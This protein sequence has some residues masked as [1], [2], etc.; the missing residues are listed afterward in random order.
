MARDKRDEVRIPDVEIIIQAAASDA[1][2][3]CFYFPSDVHGAAE[4]VTAVSDPSAIPHLVEVLRQA[5]T[6][7]NSQDWFTV[8]GLDTHL[9]SDEPDIPF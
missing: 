7:L 9:V 1:A 5:I 3:V 2:S 6:S 8:D 4:V